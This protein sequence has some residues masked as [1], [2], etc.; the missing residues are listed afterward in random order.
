[1]KSKKS[2]NSKHLKKK[3]APTIFGPDLQKRIDFEK[4]PDKQK[5]VKT[6]DELR[7]ENPLI[8]KIAGALNEILDP[9]LGIGIVDLGLIYGIALE[10]L[11]SG[12]HDAIIIMTL[13][14]MGC[15]VGPMI[16]EQVESTVPLLISDIESAS[17]Q[18][19]WDPPWSPDRMKPEIKDMVFGF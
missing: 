5:P 19:V 17:V 12:K 9:E 6:L 2:T 8:D 7:E 13:T 4:S 16:M 10:K 18:I 15:P 11:P 14:S 1:M 3:P